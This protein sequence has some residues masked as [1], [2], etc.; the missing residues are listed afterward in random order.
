MPRKV[1]I[2]PAIVGALTRLNKEAP[3]DD[4]TPSTDGGRVIVT[5]EMVEYCVDW[6]RRTYGDLAVATH[7]DMRDMLTAALAA[8]TQ[9]EG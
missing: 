9:P 4:A 1:K 6:T 8:H 2:T 7:S 3:V 5:D